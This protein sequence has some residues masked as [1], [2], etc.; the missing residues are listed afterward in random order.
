MRWI[1]RLLVL[2]MIGYLALPYYSLYR[3]DHALAANDTLQL[4]RYIDLDQVRSGL[5]RGL[6]IEGSGQ[7]EG[8]A[9]R[10][11]RGTANSM[12]AFTVD[13]VATLDWVRQQL[14]GA[15][16]EQEALSLFESLDHAFFESPNRFL[17]RLG[18]LSG[19][20]LFFMM[21]REGLVWRVTELY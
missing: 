10:I 15:G 9:S 4:N 2:A 11:F 5:K 13:R 1:M 3:L 19:D 7:Q 8:M 16:G 21:R 14:S 17:V 6:R 20:H 12:S 18:E